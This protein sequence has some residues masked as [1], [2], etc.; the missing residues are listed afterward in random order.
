[1]NKKIILL[2]SMFMMMLVLG[3]NVFA[4][5]S[6]QVP[7]IY[8]SE[9]T[10]TTPDN[11]GECLINIRLRN[12]LITIQQVHPWRARTVELCAHFVAADS[13]ISVRSVFDNLNTYVENNKYNSSTRA[14][15]VNSGIK[16]YI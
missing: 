1:M 12:P 2:I 7:D 13:D 14:T 16:R 3:S 15:I 4:L 5:D 6:T 10:I 8:I 11:Y 9:V